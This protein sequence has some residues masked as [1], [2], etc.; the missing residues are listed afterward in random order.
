MF[1]ELTRYRLRH[2]TPLVI[3]EPL[4]AKPSVASSPKPDPYAKAI[5]F[6]RSLG[7]DREEEEITLQR[8]KHAHL[9]QELERQGFKV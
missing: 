2:S 9:L 7:L 5:A 6:V 8:L 3:E 4:V 1:R